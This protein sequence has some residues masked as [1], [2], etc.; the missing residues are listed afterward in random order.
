MNGQLSATIAHEQ[1]VIRVFV[2]ST[3]RDMHAERDELVKRA[4]PQLRK[5]CE[6]RGVTWSEV[7]LRWGVTEEQSKRG[8]VLPICL[9]EIQRCRPYFIGLLGERY[10]WVPDEILPELIEQEPW[11]KEHPQHSVTE[12]EILHGV[13]NDP[14]MA[15]SALFYFRDPAFIDGLPPDEQSDYLEL[16]TA[17]ETARYGHPEAERH[18]KERRQ[19]LAS[20]KKRIRAHGRLSGYEVHENYPN[21]QALGELVLRDFTAI[22]DRLY[23]PGSDPDPL[24]REALDHEAFAQSRA[25]V[26]IGRQ[27][28]YDRLDDHARGDGPPLVV[29][30]ESGAGK[31][32]LLSN[33][34]LRYRAA[35]P[36]ELLLMHFIGATSYSADWAAM[37]R[38][39]MNEFKRRFDI[40][41]EIPDKPDELRTAFANWL[42]MAAAKGR[43]VLML[44]ALN[45]LEDSEGAPDLIWLPPVIPANVR[46]ILST[47]SGRPLDDLKRRGWPTTQIEP[48]EVDERKQLIKEYLDQH[49]KQLSAAQGERIASADQAANPLY[50]RALLDELRVFGAHEK[51]DTRIEHYLTA[52]SI[53]ELY[54]K[55]LERYEQDYERERPGLVRDAMSLLWAARRGLSETELLEL[56]GTEQGPLPQAHW[57]PLYL[58]ADQSLVI[59]AGLIG[60]GHEYLH[61]AVQNKYLLTESDQR[62]TRL[63]LADYFER[64]PN[65]LRKIDELPWQLL[66][67][68]TWERLAS[69]L[70]DLP[71][72]K[73]TAQRAIAIYWLEVEAH[74]SH[75]M[76]DAYRGVL[77][78][79]G[80]YSEYIGSV[81][82]QLSARAHI[83]EAATLQQFLVKKFRQ[84]GNLKELGGALGNLAT[85]LSLGGALEDALVVSVEMEE[86]CRKLSN[87]KDLAACFNIQGYIL[88]G[89]GDRDQSLKLFKKAELLSRELEDKFLL[90]GSL[91]NQGAVLYEKG[92][93]LN[94]TLALYQQEEQLWLQAGDRFALKNVYR[95][96][97]DVLLKLG[98]LTDAMASQKKAEDICRELGNMLWLQ[99]SLGAQAFISVK[100][101]DLNG[102]LS[103]WKQQEHICRTYGY[104]KDLVQALYNQAM[105]IC[106]EM[107]RY[108]DGLPLAE[109]AFKLANDHGLTVLAGQ[110]KPLLDSWQLRALLHPLIQKS[111]QEAVYVS[112]PH[113]NADPEREAQLNIKH[114]EELA[115][116][117]EEFVRWESLP[118]W[119]RFRAKRPQPPKRI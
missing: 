16:P 60:F 90:A 95:K 102:S 98:R 119:K 18:A 24:D 115:R 43:V 51:L 89:Q 34:A 63:R 1:R 96:Q 30:G 28:Y 41:Q 79:P 55:I 108:G 54:E 71:F 37:L 113:P 112:T 61:W 73:N 105:T 20:L 48:L 2:S 53:D 39:A 52:T 44:D 19:K 12:L 33:W 22:I 117:R 68:Q 107:G 31:S 87:K 49:A 56:L 81:S 82:Y 35:Y 100:L 76:I 84:E 74:S 67:A 6:S 110:I 65:S 8:E 9:A 66:K 106:Q 10:G 11:L 93:D 38:R 4:F 42:Y 91:G 109:E 58:A 40:Q 32:A 97:A 85:F 57:S 14:Q 104:T 78:N 83:R 17:E 46:L 23:P 111:P 99:V 64:R 21:P 3:F 45:Q 13:L 72:L 80:S 75:N 77:E 94:E 101:G 59:Q 69:L 88:L 70:A 50:L 25:R 47:L 27:S 5:L 7:D 116:W 92:G 26:Y 118:W 29:L 15:D 103:L 36:D 62:E 114:Q 86:V